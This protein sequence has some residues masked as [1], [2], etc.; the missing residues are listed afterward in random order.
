M[1][2]IKPSIT[3][4]C[5]GK[6][7]VIDTGYTIPQA[8]PSAGIG[9]P[10]VTIWGLIN[11]VVNGSYG[12]PNDADARRRLVADAV[13]MNVIHK[14]NT[15]SGS[16]SRVFNENS[17]TGARGSG[18]GGWIS[19]EWY[20]FCNISFDYNGQQ[21]GYGIYVLKTDNATGWDSTHYW[22]GVVTRFGDNFQY[23]GGNGRG[24]QTP[25]DQYEMFVFAGIARWQ[26]GFG[27]E[28]CYI[29]GL[30]SHRTLVP[31]DYQIE[32]FT[33]GYINVAYAQSNFGENHL[34]PDEDSDPNDDAGIT[35]PKG[36]DQKVHDEVFEHTID[37]QMPDITMYPSTAA[38]GLVTL[39]APSLP[40]IQS[41]ADELWQD[42]VLET[43][44]QYFGKPMDAI[45]G[46]GVLPFSP[47]TSGYKR[48]KIGT[49]TCTTA[50][51]VVTHQFHE[52]DCGGLKI[53][54]AWENYLDYSPYTR[55]MIYLP[56]VGTRELDVDEIMGHTLYVKYRVDC[57][58]GNLVAF[59]GI[60]GTSGMAVRYQFSGNCMQQLPVNAQSFDNMLAAGIQLCT[61][62]A[63][64]I[65]AG[66]QAKHRA[67]GELAAALTK[68]DAA[69]VAS[70][71]INF[72]LGQGRR[73]A[74]LASTA[75][76]AVMAAKP[77]VEKSGAIGAST[78]Q[79]SVQTPF[80]TRI[81]P[82]QSLPEKYMRYKGY[83]LNATSP[84]GDNPGFTVVDDV[85]LNNLP[86]TIPEIDEI[87][88]LLG[89]GV[90]V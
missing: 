72:K 76:D 17:D 36:K 58:N 67:A 26:G 46:M 51:P 47:P 81:M 68:N 61:A 82:R 80:I 1:S 30:L 74:S 63:G 19:G 41:F 40:L 22:G 50:L 2:A 56:Y 78:G 14:F 88:K 35:D 85:R 48:P 44:F 89:E 71:A 28:R 64:S 69:G 5:I 62:L 52:I 31:Y 32:D 54:P 27:E 59:V 42:N 13:A 49:Y 57:Y 55:I 24:L 9:N 77:R 16:Y 7:P 60:D 18:V 6:V 10:P 79:M 45:V 73:D 20:N 29:F 4:P 75:A 25:L 84:I 83:P 37:I 90:I 87:Y 70:S 23:V 53:E 86:A 12:V 65:A 66:G 8:R 34:L 39:Y 43:I 38:A 33:R 15:D 11:Y 21:R 3:T